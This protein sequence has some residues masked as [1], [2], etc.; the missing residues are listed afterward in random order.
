MTIPEPNFLESIKF[1][2]EFLPFKNQTEIKFWW[3]KEVQRM[4]EFYLKNQNNL[5]E[6]KD[7]KT[8]EEISKNAERFKINCVLGNNWGGKSRLF[9]WILEKEHILN[10]TAERKNIIGILM[11]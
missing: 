5:P 2:K 1:E 11:I 10:N 3:E 9:E 7:K 6:N 4:I 8:D